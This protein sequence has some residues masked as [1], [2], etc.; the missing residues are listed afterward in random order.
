MKT[1][2]ELLGV[3][4][5][6]TLAEIE[7]GFRQ[8]LDAHRARRGGMRPDQDQHQ[9]QAIAAAYRVLSSPTRRNVYDQKLQAEQQAANHKAASRWA[10][11]PWA[12]LICLALLIAAGTAHRYNKAQE[13]RD[14]ETMRPIK[15]FQAKSNTSRT[16]G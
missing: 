4:R 3:G 7:Q 12:I 10:W 15:K 5:Q 6:A 8:S 13:Q 9:L 16:P 2:Y 1:L 11:I 14:A